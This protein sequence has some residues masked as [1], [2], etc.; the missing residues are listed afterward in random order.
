M[1]AVAVP[2]EGENTQQLDLAQA[3]QRAIKLSL[4]QSL[5]SKGIHEVCKAIEAKKAKFCVLAEN[6]NEN[7]YKKLVQALCKEN[8]VPLILVKEAET[9]GEWIGICKKD[10]QNNIRKKRKCSSLLI[11]DFPTELTVDER[12]IIEANF[13]GK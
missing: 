2:V 9:L 11:R 4:H 6:C 1:A 5:L 7:N 10:S 12:M 8:D 13:G 3:L